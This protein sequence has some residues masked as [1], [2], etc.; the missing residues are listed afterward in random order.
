MRIRIF[1]VTMLFFS[2]NV[3]AGCIS[4]DCVSGYGVY[5]WDN[6]DKYAGESKGNLLHGQGTYTYANG[7]NAVPAKC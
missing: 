3:F 1:F 2:F 6:G 5:E 4:G 7:E